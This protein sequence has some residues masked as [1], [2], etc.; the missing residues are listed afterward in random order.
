MC[1]LHFFRVLVFA[2]VAG[3][4]GMLTFIATARFYSTST[5]TS[6]YAGVSSLALPHVR[7]ATLVYLLL[8]FHTYVM[9]RWCIFSCPWAVPVINLERTRIHVK[10]KLFEF[11]GCHKN[12]PFC[13]VKC[14]KMSKIGEHYVVL[15]SL[16]HIDMMQKC[17]KPSGN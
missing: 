10:T 11:N 17:E 2:L 6:C 13:E 14:L 1:C 5:H 4:G 12:V 16:K 3:W 8:Y 15:C 7:H 9:L